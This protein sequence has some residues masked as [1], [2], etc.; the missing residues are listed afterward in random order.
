MKTCNRCNVQKNLNE[1]YTDSSKSGYRYI[2]KTCDKK[3]IKN[4]QLQFKLQ[5]L[6]YKGGRFCT[7]CGYN[8][9]VGALDFHHLDPSQKDFSIGMGKRKFDWD[10]TKN[11]LDKCIV[12]CS[13]CHRKIHGG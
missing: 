13:N 6:D 1:F 12:V 9:Y 2:C 7:Q 10:K 4:I 5:C 3:R 8:E 11:E